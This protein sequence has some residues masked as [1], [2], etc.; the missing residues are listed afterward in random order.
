MTVILPHLDT[1][2]VRVCNCAC[3]GCNHLSP[4]VTVKEAPHVRPDALGHDL[5]RLAE[6]AHT[7]AW[8][9]LGGE[10]TIHPDLVELLH[11]ARDTG[12][13]DE[14]E[15]WTNGTLLKRMKPA[16][17]DA[18]DRLVLSAYPGKMDDEA[19]AWVEQMC[20][21]TDTDF[22][23]KDARHN[24]YF[25]SLM[26]KR[27]VDEA[28]ARARHAQC[29]YRTYTRNVN[30]GYF[31]KC[32]TSPWLSTLMLGLP[33]GHD[34]LSLDGI[35]EE[36]LRDFLDTSEPLASCSICLGHNGPHR[37]WVEVRGREAWVE[38]SAI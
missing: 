12:I 26:L 1:D 25:T 24:S 23:I 35:T 21:D 30:N 16:F 3:R 32:C 17:W 36:A 5:K 33:A 7:K 13:A 29:W 37:D 15:V 9:A 8:A 11:I 6:V 10:P 4:M 31:Y 28:G 2:V 38:A 19:V 22:V 18:L 14:I 20:V 34:G 27:P